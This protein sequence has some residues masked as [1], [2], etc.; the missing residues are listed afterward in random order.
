VAAG[1]VL[2][3]SST[4]FVF[5]LG[6][7]VNGFTYDPY[8]GEFVLTHPHIQIPKR[9]K[10]YSFN[11]VWVRR[12]SSHGLPPATSLTRGFKSHLHRLTGG[13]GMRH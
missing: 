3:S 1:Y 12:I 6:Q 10:I 7:G 8:I 2:Y 11:E 5:T 4:T 9:G 13:S